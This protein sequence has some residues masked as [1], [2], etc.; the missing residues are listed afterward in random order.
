MNCDEKSTDPN[1]VI[2]GNVP[3]SLIGN[4]GAS[5]YIFTN[6]ANPLEQVD[7]I[8]LGITLLLNI[9]SNGT[10][11]STMTFPNDPPETETGT[12]NFQNNIVTVNPPGDDPFAM[13]YVL[14]DSILTF[15]RTDS[16]FD[17]D[18]DGT[19]EPA[20]ETIIFVKQ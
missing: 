2:G 8:Q 18:D 19:D 7:I 4:W 16:E 13:T 6:T 15:M 9:Q 12:V 3:D 1:K 20:T 11:T 17:F 10:Y 14:V 5:N